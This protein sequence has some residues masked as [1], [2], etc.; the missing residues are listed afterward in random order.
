MPLA[1]LPRLHLPISIGIILVGCVLI[2]VGRL[3]HF[4]VYSVGPIISPMI[5][6]LLIISGISMA[7]QSTW[8]QVSRL[9]LGCAFLSTAGFFFCLL[10]LR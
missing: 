3:A 6:L 7:T 2:A 10:F 1:P 8:P 9:L 5:G 4:P